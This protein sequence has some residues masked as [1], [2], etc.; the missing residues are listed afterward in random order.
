MVYGDSSPPQERAHTVCEYYGNEKN[1]A[2]ARDVFDKWRTS[3]TVTMG[4]REVPF[5]MIHFVGGMFDTLFVSCMPHAVVNRTEPCH[6]ILIE[7]D[8]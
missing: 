1:A 7:D 4:R 6:M 5:K 2:I 8:F 3:R